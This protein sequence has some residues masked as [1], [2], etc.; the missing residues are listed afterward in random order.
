MFSLS[1]GFQPAVLD[2]AC[3]L[4]AD[5]RSM[6]CEEDSREVAYLAC[7]KDLGSH[8]ASVPRRIPAAHLRSSVVAA[9]V[10]YGANGNGGLADAIQEMD[11]SRADL[12]RSIHSLANLSTM[13]RKGSPWIR[14]G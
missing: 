9:R 6:P 2:L 1:L 8:K 4:G 3:G 7:H 11:E 12:V 13:G 10:A 14:C 5:S